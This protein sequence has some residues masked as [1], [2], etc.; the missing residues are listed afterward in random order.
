MLKTYRDIGGKRDVILTVFAHGWHHSAK[1]GDTNIESFKEML[2]KIS[3]S[4]TIA[5][6]QDNREKREI[7]GVYIGWR[8][9]SMSIKYL[10]SITFWGRK[11]VAHE[12]GQQGV[13][14]ALLRLEEIVNVRAGFEMENPKPRNSRMVV[15]G[16]SFGGA[17]VFTA[18]QQVMADRFI[19]SRPG[20]TYSNSAQG[21]GDLVVLMNPAFEA[22][23]YSTLFD[24]SQ[25]C[26]ESS[27]RRYWPDQMPRLA[28]LTSEG[29]I[30]T[31]MAFPA[32][33]VFSTMFETHDTLE[34]HINTSAE[35]KPVPIEIKES[36]A[37]TTTIGHFEPYWTHRLEPLANDNS[38]DKDF[39]LR[40]LGK[41]WSEQ[42]YGQ[43]LEF[44]H[45]ALKHLKR[46]HPLN[47]YL[48]IYVSEEL[49]PDH[50][51]IW[52]DR[53]IAFIEDLI[54]ISTTPIQAEPQ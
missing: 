40:S 29:D 10:N 7:L 45:V 21:F 46:S 25:S 15:I 52:G 47:P 24:I 48:N 2:A 44:E 5:A 23:R 22:M 18:L 49:I 17:V 54:T 42:D 27:C 41:G 8:G 34:R 30:A 50:N 36:K 35:N 43:Q 9:D 37:D 33:R 38:R 3:A 6:A 31:G 53:V 16:H 11:S 4:E 51:K 28:V 26:G 20:K 1:P 19:D 39:V 12:V 14:E 32:G 13:T